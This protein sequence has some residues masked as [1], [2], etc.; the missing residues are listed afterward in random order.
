DRFRQKGFRG[1]FYYTSGFYNGGERR[2]RIGVVTKKLVPIDGQ[3]K[4]YAY[5]FLRKLGYKQAIL[6]HVDTRVFSA[7]SYLARVLQKTDEGWETPDFK[8]GPKSLWVFPKGKR[9]KW[10]EQ[11]AYQVKLSK[12]SKHPKK[13]KKLKRKAQFGKLGNLAIKLKS[14][15]KVES[16]IARDNGTIS[17]SFTNIKEK[18]K[19]GYFINPKE[20]S[21]WVLS[22][23][24]HDKSVK[25][26]STILGNKDFRRYKK[27]ILKKFR[28][29][30]VL[31]DMTKPDIIIDTPDGYL[32]PDV[33]ETKKFL[34]F[35][36]SPTG[37]GKT[38]KLVKWLKGLK[39][40]DGSVLIISV[41]RTQAVHTDR[42]LMKKGLDFLCYLDRSLNHRSNSKFYNTKFIEMT[43]KGKAP[44]RLICG[45][46]SLHH[47]ISNGR[48]LRNYDYVI[49]DE[50]S[51]LPNSAVNT[52][53]LIKDE[54][55]R[56]Y[57]DMKALCLLLRN[58]KR[59]ICLDGYV[60]APVIKAISKISKKPPY[61]I[62][63]IYQTNKKV[64]I[65]VTNS[66]QQPAL[67]GDI[68]CEKFMNQ[69]NEDLQKP[70]KTNRI[71]TIACSYKDRA[72]KLSNY[73]TQ[74]YPNKNVKLITADI[75]KKSELIT[76][77]KDLDD[78]ISHNNISVLIYSPTITTGVDIKEAEDMNVY[79]LMNGNELSSHTHYQ[80]TMRGR[81]AATYKILIPQYMFKPK[82]DK[83]NKQ[84]VKG[85][86][87][88][89]IK[90]MLTLLHYRG[91]YDIKA[92]LDMLKKE[93]LGTGSL[94]TYKH[95]ES[96]TP[97]KK[98]K[99]ALKKGNL[100]QITKDPV[101]RTAIT[102]ERAHLDWI[103][104]DHKYG[105]AGQYINLLARE[106]CR[107]SV[108]EDTIA[109][110][111]NYKDNDANRK[112]ELQH[113]IRHYLNYHGS[114]K[115]TTR[116]LYN[117]K[118]YLMFSQRILC[119]IIHN[120]QHTIAKTQDTVNLLLT[121]FKNYGIS[122]KLKKPLTLSKDQCLDMYKDLISKVDPSHE[123]PGYKLFQNSNPSDRL[124]VSR[125]AKLL[126]YF[127][128]VSKQNNTIQVKQDIPLMKS[129]KRPSDEQL[130]V[131]FS[132]NPMK[133]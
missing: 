17:I 124:K 127:F 88:Q 6:K 89:I 5:Q 1:F 123:K 83:D 30:D 20:R 23:P 50:V 100:W 90:G 118:R 65:Y 10:I 109:K 3:A 72:H 26:I 81:N 13:R 22:H 8:T 34:L 11:K 63:K 62:R 125:V 133:L 111:Y 78:Y 66:S 43:R 98:L 101:I 82:D 105:T 61:L 79:H 67:Q 122:P 115:T 45:I 112:A 51:T 19:G 58:A 130:R 48:L 28:L 32:K 24:N 15:A 94:L 2:V 47:L 9:F 55:K 54:Y 80:M 103:N 60:S 69:L 113:H 84:P 99:Q 42:Y 57:S 39:G 14:F 21:P 132:V 12:L 46:L 114:L 121:T 85:S 110:K 25:Y 56:F 86:K 33:F 16:A 74:K 93:G 37:S 49:I 102:L 76:L 108:E 106:G 68:T 73:I 117:Q 35:I 29:P 91:G 116:S 129:I 27:Y 87:R 75:T 128:S 41:N 97:K 104:Y 131:L 120:H 36:E 53:D 92:L 38:T 40:L 7:E 52:L 70:I 31:R 95:H 126:Q 18:T 77:I 107:V 4:F 119:T 96:Q 44:K 64:E 71:L 59:I